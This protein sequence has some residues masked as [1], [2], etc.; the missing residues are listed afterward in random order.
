MKKVGWFKEL[1]HGSRNGPS[2][3]DAIATP[4]ARDEVD[5][6][7]PF[8]QS[9]HVLAIGGVRAHDVLNSNRLIC[10]GL[11]VLTDGFYVWY[12]DLAYYVQEY[13][14]RLPNEFLEHMRSEHWTMRKLTPEE[15]A[16]LSDQLRLGAEHAI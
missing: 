5:R 16:A 6:I 2:L 4:M 11:K 14:A 7:V 8:L 9:G 13:G 3:R 15:F 10:A 1:G 12:G